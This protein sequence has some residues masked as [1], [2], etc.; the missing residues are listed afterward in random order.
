M[1][2]TFELRFHTEYGQSLYLTGNHELFGN[3]SVEAAVPLEYRDEGAW[4]VT[5]MIPASVVP[6]AWISY[7]YILRQPDGSIVYDW[8]QDRSINLARLSQNDARIIDSW[9]QA[10][11]YE[12]AFYTEPFT[13]VLLKSNR[14]PIPSHEST[15]TLAREGQSPDAGNGRDGVSGALAAW[16]ERNHIFKVKAPLLGETETVCLLGN[17]SELKEWDTRNPILLNRSANDPW[18]SAKLDLPATDA[19]IAYKYGV[20]DIARQAFV[21][22]EEGGNR[23]LPRRGSPSALTIVQDG[24]VR[25]PT[26]T[27]RGA[28]VAIP[29]FSLRTEKSFGVGDFSDLKFLVD[30]CKL[31]GLKLIQVLPINDTI[32]THTWQDSYPYAAISAFALHP[33]YMNLAAA[34][35]QKNQEILGQLEPERQRLNAQAEVDYEAVIK[36]KL[37]FLRQI[38]P[39]QKKTTFTR[40]PFSKFFEQNRHWLVPHA[41]FSYLR[42]KYATANFNEWPEH[43]RYRPD[44]I[45]ALTDEGSVAG[46]EIDFHYF[47]QYHLHAQLQEA[48]AYAHENGVVLK[49]D[50][51]IG[52]SRHGVDAWQ[53]PDLFC[54]AMQA[55]APP[56]PFGTKGQNWGFPTYN[57]PRM[58]LTGFEWWKRRFEQMSHYFDAFRIDHILGFFRI[59]S[60]PTHSV[61]GILGYFVRA[62]P[63]QR[64]ELLAL[65]IPFERGRLL[66]PYITDPVL[67][68]LFGNDTEEVKAQ[69]LSLD[70][71]GRYVFKP[72]F[73]TQRQVEQHFTQFEENEHSSG[74]KLRLFDLLS[75]V[76]LLHAEGAPEDEFHFR[77]DMQKTS[78]FRNLAP[79]TQAALNDLYVDYFYRR[80]EG[81]WRNEGLEKLPALKRVTH[82]LVCG[83]DL[84]MV[85]ACV[86]GVMKELGLL[87]L[88]VQ[89]M[90]KVAQREFSSPK[91]ATY[92]S[93]VT[94]STHD[95]STIRGWWEEDAAVTT[96]FYHS[97]LGQTGAPPA[98][99]ETW[100]NEA[101]VQQ[102]LAS[103]A[104]WSI[105]QLQDLL[106]MDEE[107]RRPNPHEERINVPANP[108]NQ[109]RYRM[110][111]T[112][113][114]LKEA[115]LFNNK[116]KNL[117]QAN[118]R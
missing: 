87:S 86:P 17:L 3:G 44:L 48:T 52:V 24:F 2:L 63:V 92:L 84:G 95:M 25:L 61:E 81:F 116:L 83:E 74:L 19:P 50:I 51:A 8:G 100:I 102:H 43:R 98:R 55:G 68:E 20:Y 41:V 70:S 21:R 10:G 9:N 13:A 26:G 111:V 46:E 103:P 1:R 59:W 33:L 109:W 7:N 67:L 72:E 107:L 11:F 45:T 42:D 106:G 73:A 71:R 93:V 32:A 62:L 37:D 79:E 64:Q 97:E 56:D 114:F 91:D 31:V 18:F 35:D 89:R 110:H 27:W 47:L 6:D 58:K 117:V 108:K 4:Q 12:N 40:A 57:W 36:A 96:K 104:M 76:V 75:N 49:G 34:A 101:I 66:K 69:F 14:T 16:E 112:L 118:G 85:P 113:E 15:S 22:F 65:G 115:K 28:G 105:F 39:T 60:I 38:Y 80:Q 30:W 29:V 77:F 5:L 88:E 94:P 53:A 99:C 54:M 90:P 82:M 23:V 78:S